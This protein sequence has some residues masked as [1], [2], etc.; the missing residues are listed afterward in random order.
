MNAD[1]QLS[2]NT[3]ATTTTRSCDFCGDG[4]SISMFDFF[5]AH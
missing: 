4:L 5:T 3:L 1:R 2:A